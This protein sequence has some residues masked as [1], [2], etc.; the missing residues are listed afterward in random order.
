MQR[1]FPGLLAALHEVYLRLTYMLQIHA[2]STHGQFEARQEHSPGR[3]QEYPCAAC[4]AAVPGTAVETQMG[5]T[6]D[7]AATSCA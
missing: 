7:F 3:L 2:E 1:L 5:C 6:I 4:A